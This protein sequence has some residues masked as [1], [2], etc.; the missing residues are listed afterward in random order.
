[1]Q[2]EDGKEA[3][4]SDKRKLNKKLSTWILNSTLQYKFIENCHRIDQEQDRKIMKMH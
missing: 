2:I 1:M 4:D 3:N